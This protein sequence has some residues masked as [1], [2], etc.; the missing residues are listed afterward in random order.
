MSEL[1]IDVPT[2]SGRNTPYIHISDPAAESSWLAN[3]LLWAVWPMDLTLYD[4]THNRLVGLPK[5]NVVES[6]AD[7]R[8]L[9]DI[10][11]GEIPSLLRDLDRLW[12]L[13][14]MACYDRHGNMFQVWAHRHRFAVEWQ[15]LPERDF[16]RHQ[17]WVAG[18][19]GDNNAMVRF[20]PPDRCLE[21]HA[22]EALSMIDAHFLWVAFL[23]GKP[24][25]SQYQWREVTEELRQPAPS[26][27]Y[28]HQRKEEQP[29]P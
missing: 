26:P 8:Q 11:P 15:V 2:E 17:I 7:G 1:F 6:P 3:K 18:R 21:L 20:G 27:R 13:S 28:R 16:S 10:R 29:P 23:A 14:A 19:N 5:H 22:N 9:V 25:P 24:R 4:E 12:H